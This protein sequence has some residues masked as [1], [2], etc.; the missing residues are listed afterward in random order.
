ALVGC[1]LAGSD[2]DAL[3][4]GPQF[5]SFDDDGSD[6]SVDLLAG[7]HTDVGEVTVERVG[8]NLVIKYIVVPG[9]CA[10]EY[11][12]DAGWKNGSGQIKRIPTD[13]G[14]NPMIGRFGSSGDPDCVHLIT[15]TV[16]LDHVR[17]EGWTDGNP[18]V[19]A[20]HAVVENLGTGADCEFL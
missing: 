8:D 11:H 12:L 17:G 9:W 6:G 14:G 18:V 2:P 1:D 19:I 5:A 3:S 4:G 15:V 7:Q 13:G 16:P 20:A 10:T